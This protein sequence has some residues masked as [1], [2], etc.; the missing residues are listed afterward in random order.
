[1]VALLLGLSVGSR[2]ELVI[3]ITQGVD[4]TIPIAVVP[5]AQPWRGGTAD[6]GID[7]VISAD[8]SRSGWFSLLPAESMLE[9]PF[10]SANV[11]YRDWRLL[12]VEAIVVGRVELTGPD[13]FD[14]R[15]E[16]LD[17]VRGERLLGA[18]YSA[19]SAAELR[20]LGHHIADQVFKQLTGVEGVFS[21]RIAYVSSTPGRYQLQVA[22]IDGRNPVG[23]LAS[24]EP[25]LSPA[26]S[27]DGEHLAYVAF[28]HGRPG[29]YR[30]EVATG[31]REKLTEF[32]GIN[33]APAW[34]PDGRE[35]AITLSKAGSPDLYLYNL[36]DGLLT[37][38][39]SHYAIETEP[40]WSP[41][42]RF[43]YYTSDRGGRPQ[44]Y[45]IARQGGAS[46]RITVDMGPYNARPSVS[47]D[48]KYLAVVNSQG[49]GNY[50]IGLVD[51]EQSHMTL[52]SDGRLDESPSFAPNGRLIIYTKTRG[53]DELLAVISID[54]KV[55]QQLA[56]QQASVREPAWSPF[57]R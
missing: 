48:G 2:A 56:L 55:R 52:L 23:V 15:F 14:V 12:N 5:F 51:L 24:P 9:R 39:T 17:T 41:D 29:I 38:L 1:M 47:A 43:I 4:A 6:S 19:V 22:D 35:L 44:I 36:S 20:R 8:L 40:A 30:Q 32:D 7:Q 46:E 33:G 31:N 18:R 50:R 21:T 42:G 13:L 10:Q 27:H 25:V 53:N 26:W 16:L 54:A 57:V 45:R 3:D 49:D 28:E 11:D 37:R 34:S